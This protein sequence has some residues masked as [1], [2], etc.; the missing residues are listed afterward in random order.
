MGRV[1]TSAIDQEGGGKEDACLGEPRGG[2]VSLSER[3]HMPGGHI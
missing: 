1:V 2:R 3:V